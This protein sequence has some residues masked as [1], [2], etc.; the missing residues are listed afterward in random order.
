MKILKKI[1]LFIAGIGVA[2]V[3]IGVVAD[4]NTEVEVDPITSSTT[5]SFLMGFT[6]AVYENTPR[7]YL[8]GLSVVKENAD[9]LGIYLDDGVPWERALNNDFDSDYVDDLKGRAKL[10]PG[11]HKLLL[12]LTPISFGRDGLATHTGAGSAPWRSEFND[13][14]VITAYVNYIE[15]MI[16]IFDPDYLVYAIEINILY[17]NNESLW[18]GF[19]EFLPQVYVELKSRH[20]ELP[21]L[22]SIHAEHFHKNKNRQTE[23][24]GELISFTDF[25]TVSAHPFLDISNPDRIPSDYFGAIE[26]LD[27]N[28]PFVIAE[29]S[30]PAE[31]ITSPYPRNIRTTPEDQTAYL[32]RLFADAEELDAVFVLWFFTR[33]YD[34]LWTSSMKDSPIA[35]ILRIWR[36]TG[37]YDGDGDPRPALGFWRETLSRKLK[38]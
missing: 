3:L 35:H 9:L 2:I 1:V 13:P 37:L 16:E 22:F 34:I 17:A 8:D 6:D 4:N 24:L 29:T 10:V 26:N 30:W 36:D 14:D 15:K 20:E 7:A 19:A 25:V 32:H 33:D 11:S 21:L 12:A 38:N 27:S 23:A 18:D 31:D 28:K 5:R